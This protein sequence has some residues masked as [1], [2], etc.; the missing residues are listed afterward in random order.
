VSSSNTEAVASVAANRQ[1]QPSR[2]SGCNQP[3]PAQGEFP[4]RR[5]ARPKD[6][7]GDRSLGRLAAT[8]G[9]SMVARHW[10]VH[11]HSWLRARQLVPKM[12]AGLHAWP[13]ARPTQL[14]GRGGHSSQCLFLYF[15]DLV[16]LVIFFISCILTTVDPLN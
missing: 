9:P 13:A 11:T 12:A 4:R 5:C 16:N 10:P 2:R 15:V 8:I 3:D 7:G 14:K 1:L 6:G